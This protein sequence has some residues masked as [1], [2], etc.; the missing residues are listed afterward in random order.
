[1]R[2]ES[3]VAQAPCSS[4][5]RQEERG[6]G[7]GGGGGGGRGGGGGGGGGEEEG[8]KEDS[9]EV[10]HKT[11]HRGSGTT[12][13]FRAIL[14]FRY[15]FDDLRVWQYYIPNLR[16]N[17][18][19]FPGWTSVL[20]SGETWGYNFMLI[21]S[22]HDLR[23]YESKKFNIISCFEDKRTFKPSDQGKVCSLLCV[24]TVFLEC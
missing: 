10:N 24:L 6:G 3:N 4:G 9:S 5:K 1:M 8:R 18:V 11:T 7:G 12:T 13:Y 21:M 19:P 2:S 17:S 14:F 20:G 16:G 23:F 22:I 15:C